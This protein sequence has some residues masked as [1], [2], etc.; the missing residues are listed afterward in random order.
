[1]NKKDQARE[2]VRRQLCLMEEC[3]IEPCCSGPCHDELMRKVD[4]ILS[5]SG[6][7][8]RISVVR[9][10][11]ELPKADAHNNRCP[12]CGDYAESQQDMVNAGWV[13]E[14]K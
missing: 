9:E 2:A 7:G 11:G 6:P 13:Q 5:L 10:K 14:V 3:D 1:M 4:S 12:Y 8:W